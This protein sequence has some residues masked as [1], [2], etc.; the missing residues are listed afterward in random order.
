MNTTNEALQPSSFHPRTNVLLIAL[1][2]IAAVTLEFMGIGF[3][4]WLDSWFMNH[5]DMP[6]LR[7]DKS[8]GLLILIGFLTSFHCMGICDPLILSYTAKSAT[9]GH[10]SHGTI[11]F[12]V[13]V[14]RCPILLSVHCLARSARSSP[15]RR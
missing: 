2:K 15:L 14:K 3:I 12:M 4:L 13:S 6:K 7:R 1:K 8:Y 10:K 9:N 5:S 11:S